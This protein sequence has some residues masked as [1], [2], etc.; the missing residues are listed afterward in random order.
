MFSPFVAVPS[1]LT[2]VTDFLAEHDLLPMFFCYRWVLLHFKREFPI[3][4]VPTP[5]H[6]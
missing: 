1:F 2:V 4:Q 5:C 6:R 3:D